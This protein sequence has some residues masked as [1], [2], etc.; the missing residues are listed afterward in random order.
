MF[1][2]FG[3]FIDHDLDLTPVAQLA[4]AAQPGFSTS[5]RQAVSK[6]QLPISIPS[7]DAYLKKG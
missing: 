6:D 3:Q 4:K 1:W 2:S 7:D 5:A